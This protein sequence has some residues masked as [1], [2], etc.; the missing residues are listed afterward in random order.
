MII[1]GII[2][3]HQK[4]YYNKSYKYILLRPADRYDMI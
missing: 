2:S 4:W 3:V 1:N